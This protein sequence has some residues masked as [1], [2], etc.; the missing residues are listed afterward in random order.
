M[1]TTKTAEQWLEKAVELE[2]QEKQQ[3]AEQCF[4]KAIEVEAQANAES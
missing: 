4:K 3:Q 1:E 2:A